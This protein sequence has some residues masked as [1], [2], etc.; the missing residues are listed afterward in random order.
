MNA[1]AADVDDHTQKL[2]DLWS[3]L[4]QHAPELEPYCSVRDT[5]TGC[6]SKSVVGSKS[7]W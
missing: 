1:T 7:Y 6:L 5:Y 3:Y 4:R 2:R